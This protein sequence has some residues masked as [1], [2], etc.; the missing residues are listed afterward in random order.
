V[1]VHRISDS[2]LLAARNI[3][4]TLH[5]WKQCAHGQDVG[6]ELIV[7]GGGKLSGT[8]GYMASLKFNYDLL[9]SQFQA[10]EQSESSTCSSGSSSST[11]RM[12]SKQE[13]VVYSSSTT[14]AAGAGRMESGAGNGPLN[15]I[16]WFASNCQSFVHSQ[17]EQGR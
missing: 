16:D 6:V 1:P 9:E 5:D 17:L 15:L 7:S 2:D 4:V 12:K 13:P 8:G 14:D 3:C 11:S 10:S